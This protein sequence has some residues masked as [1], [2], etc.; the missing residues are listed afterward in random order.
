M[1]NNNTLQTVTGQG[2]S[3]GFANLFRQENKKW[4]GTQRW[5]IQS[6][7][8]LVIMNGILALT[9][10]DGGGGSA[11]VIGKGV[12]LI[13]AFAHI[14]ATIGVIILAQGMIVGEK[15]SGTA[16]WVLSKPVSRVSFV[17]SKGVA[18]LIAVWVI[19]II[20]QGVAAYLQISL[21]AGRFFPPQNFLLGMAVAALHLLFYLSMTLMLGTIFNSRG[22]VIG[23]AIGILFGF[24]ILSNLFARYTPW[25]L[26][27]LPI[28]LIETV[29]EVASGAEPLAT[30]NF[31]PVIAMPI[32]SAIFMTVA[33][34]YFSREE[35]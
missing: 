4:W 10:F 8:W 5:W 12:E 23:I 32:W 20:L 29:T 25:L 30:L 33:L 24:Q 35:F 11:G 1:L 2:W 15:Q 21:A 26:E 13:V 6:L 14:F 27:I 7:I 19:M 18:T 16:A 17:L 31:N 9:L 22:A 28:T 34:W 3:R